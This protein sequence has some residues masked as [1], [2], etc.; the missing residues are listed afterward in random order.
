MKNTEEEYF[1]DGENLIV[2]F[3]SEDG[4]SLYYRQELIFPVDGM[5]FAVLVGLNVDEDEDFDE[6]ENVILAKIV[7]DE[8]GEEE[9]VEPTEEEFEAA[10]AAYDAM[11]DEEGLD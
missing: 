1:E 11:C 7:K 2:E 10:T 5:E 4:D 8:N 9:Y 6:E 3:V